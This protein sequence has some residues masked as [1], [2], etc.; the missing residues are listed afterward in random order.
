MIFKLEN[1]KLVVFGNTIDDLKD[2]WVSFSSLFKIELSD[3]LLNEF[4]SFKYEFNQSSLSAEELAEELGGVDDKIIAYAKTCKNGQLTTNGFVTSI[5]NMTVTA[6][7]AKIAMSALAT[8]GSIVAGMAISFAI[9]AALKGID[10][11]IHRAEN[12]EK[13]FK[14]AEQSIKNAK[15][16]LSDNISVINENKKRFL[17]LSQGVNEFSEN[18]SLS[19][20]EYIEYLEISQELA[21]ISP[22]LIH[23][24]NDQGQALLKIGSS[25]SETSSLL[26]EVV[27]EQQKIA[28]AEITNNFG[29]YV[30]GIHESSKDIHKII[31]NLNTNREFYN[32]EL[33]K[34][35]SDN[36]REEINFLSSN[37][38]VLID[39][40]SGVVEQRVKEALNEAGVK[41]QNVADNVI[42]ILEA[43][44]TQLQQA[45]SLFDEY[46]S[47]Q[48]KEYTLK[49]NQANK[50]LSEQERLLKQNYKAI[51]GY[52]KDIM[53]DNIDYKALSSADGNLSNLADLLIEST[54]FSELGYTNEVQYEVYYER[55]LDQIMD[56][57]KSHPELSLDMSEI[58]RLDGTLDVVDIVEQLQ[59]KFKKYNID[60]DLT[61]I[62]A[63]EKDVLDRLNNSIDKLAHVNDDSYSS[64]ESDKK[65][66]IKYTEDLTVAEA[67]LWLSVTRG[68]YSAETAIRRFEEALKDVEN[69]SKKLISTQLESLQK[70][71]D[72]WKLLSEV[73]NDVKDG[74]NF[75]YSSIL[76]NDDFKN[77]FGDLDS[78]NDFRDTIVQFPN[79]INKC[80]KAF[81]NLAT[82]YLRNEI[83]IGNLTEETKASTIAFLEQQ[84]VKNA[85]TVVTEALEAN[86]DALAIKEETLGIL[87]ANTSDIIKNQK[88]TALMDEVGATQL[89]RNYLFKLLASEKVFNSSELDVTQKIQA[90]KEYALAFKGVVAADLLFEEIKSRDPHSLNSSDLDNY[91]ELISKYDDAEVEVD[92]SGISSKAEAEKA[93]EILDKYFDY[94]EKQL[95]A[96]QITYQEYIQ[97]CND[98]REEFYRDGKITSEEYYQ[99]LADLYEKQLEYRDK[100]ISAVVDSIDNKIKGLEKDKEKL[101]DYYN[102]L[103]EK[104]QSEID[105][106]QKANDERERAIALQK[107]QYELNRALNQRIDYTYQ[108]GQFIYKA[109]DGAIR[110]AQNELDDQLFDMQISE[111]EK[112]IED[113]EDALEDATETIDQQI[114]ALNE[115]KDKWSEISS[116]Y[117]EQQNRIYAANILGADW[118]AEILNGRLD[119]LEN[120]KNEYI[121]IQQEM[122]NANVLAANPTP[123]S[124]GGGGGNG[125][126]LGGSGGN[127]GNGDGDKPTTPSY[128]PP[129][130]SINKITSYKYVYKTGDGKEVVAAGGFSSEDEAKKWAQSHGIFNGEAKVESTKYGVYV[131]GAL[132]VTRSSEQDAKDYLQQHYGITLRKYA[133]GGVVGS[134]KSPLDAIA[135]SLNEDHMVAVK[136]GERILTPIQNSYFEKLINVSADFVKLMTP[137]ENMMKAQ[138]F[139]KYVKNG[140]TNNNVV[141]NVSLNCP[142]VTNESGF[143]YIKKE[144]TSLTT[145]ALQ[146]DWG[147][148]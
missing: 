47:S 141:M 52:L 59:E 103:I 99:Y 69:T 125:G 115:Y 119:T 36:I 81:N 74:G 38:Q 9:T 106:L 62:M 11:L 76:N 56:V 97:K 112:Q 70:T 57:Y 14:E 32:E 105:E 132:Q 88:I 98:I 111:L 146:F 21:D 19:K 51:N 17:E 60:I 40:T 148:Q 136:D 79:D 54:D 90:L 135:H 86:I 23:G 34:L 130:A 63:D 144:L 41:Y 45:Q 92:Y 127:G 2:K 131:N 108:D 94:Y 122:A 142:N 68:C 116:V 140:N 95:Q 100:A 24:Y 53:H 39:D 65:R 107:A 123:T 61:P 10:Y 25:A 42:Q 121:R 120:F 102:G 20:E 139:S 129:N 89:A 80:Q 49:L 48:V 134:D 27:E 118:E 35:N 147:T 5:K 126:N 104:I 55:I 114:D 117:E 128:T 64:A 87:E 137:F 66:L 85:D 124:T 71:E 30:K 109:K 15:K 78:Y 8:V 84:G 72:G 1:D 33:N 145:K 4:E 43:S 58:F 3:D 12:I 133:K 46:A 77:S 22:N 50:E 110:D 37:G 7:A 6:K 67:E 16:T 96:G 44:D 91:W 93:T 75:D 138:D 29:D 26:H 13:A 73:Y 143:N 113:L 28:S 101:E 83:A 31:N 82:E 18:I